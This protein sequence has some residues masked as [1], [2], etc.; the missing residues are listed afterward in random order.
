MAMV[1]DESS[2]AFVRT[3]YVLDFA[4][5]FNLRPHERGASTYHCATQP[6]ELSAQLLAPTV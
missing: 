5:D 4:G 2:C 6:S 1:T 3:Q